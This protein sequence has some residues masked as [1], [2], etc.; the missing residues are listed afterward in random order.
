MR[1]TAGATI[2]N[3]TH[4]DLELD[5]VPRD[6]ARLTTKTLNATL[7]D[8]PLSEAQ[9]ASALRWVAHTKGAPRLQPAPW[10]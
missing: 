10:R 3:V 8:R 4:A 9:V 5:G 7:R 6:T 1:A 2:G